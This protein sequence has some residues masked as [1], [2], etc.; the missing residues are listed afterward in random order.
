M[1]TVTLS[2]YKKRHHLLFF[3]T[4][5]Q[6]DIR[7]SGLVGAYIK[8]IDRFTCLSIDL[9]TKWRLNVGEKAGPFFFPSRMHFMNDLLWHERTIESELF[10]GSPV[11]SRRAIPW[12]HFFSSLFRFYQSTPLHHCSLFL[13]AHHLKTW[14]PL[15]SS[16]WRQII[17]YDKRH[18]YKQSYCKRNK[19][20]ERVEEEAITRFYFVLRVLEKRCNDYIH[21]EF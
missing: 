16:S 20:R 13:Q 4:F 5:C 8:S 6:F 1:H 10:E 12:N 18:W 14:T 17:W 11:A 19:K 3:S 7:C 21:C 9:W 15:S 2:S